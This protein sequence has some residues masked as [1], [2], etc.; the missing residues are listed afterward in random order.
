MSKKSKH[1]KVCPFK[2]GKIAATEID[3]K[4]VKFL[5]KYIT[6]VGKIVQSRV[7]GVSR[8]YQ[9]AISHEIKVARYLALIPYCDN[10]K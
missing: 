9:R 8:V 4:N 5:R 2:A 6:N 3:Y 7:T 10:H 1:N